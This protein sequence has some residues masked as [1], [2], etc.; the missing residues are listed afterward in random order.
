VVP[1]REEGLDPQVLTLSG[2]VETRF[3]TWND[4]QQAMVSKDSIVIRDG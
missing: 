3:L 4:N 2:G 1:K